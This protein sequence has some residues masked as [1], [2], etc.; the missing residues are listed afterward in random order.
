MSQSSQ[1][2]LNPARVA[3]IK[4]RWHADIVDQAHLAFIDELEQL[5]GRAITV[6]VFE[7]PGAFE[8]PLQTQELAATGS[9]AAVLGCAF[10]VNGGI[11]R[12]EFVSDA[13]IS[14]LMRV[15]LDTG[16][17]VLSVVLTPHNFHESEEHRQFFHEHFKVKGREAARALVDVLAMRQGIKQAA[18]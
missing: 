14:G 2:K 15:Q 1:Q 6:D 3:F 8:I 16:V 17:P 7:V 11:Y 5:A 9:Y 10:V 12:H 4:A 18:A 13:V